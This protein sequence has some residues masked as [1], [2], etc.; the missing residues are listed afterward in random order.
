MLVDAAGTISLK[1]NNKEIFYFS[2]L[3]YDRS[4]KTG[5]VPHLQIL[6]DRVSTNLFKSLHS[7]VMEDEMKHYGYTPISFLFFAQLIAPGQF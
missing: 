4:I 6:T 3:F 1:V 2:F 5:P 7:M